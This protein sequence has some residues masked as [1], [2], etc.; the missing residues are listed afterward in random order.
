VGGDQYQGLVALTSETGWVDF[1]EAW[2]GLFGDALQVG[3]HFTSSTGH[4]TLGEESERG[5]SVILP[6]TT[7]GGLNTPEFH[8]YPTT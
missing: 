2:V 1:L 4:V 8:G 5:T 6:G 3:A 7:V